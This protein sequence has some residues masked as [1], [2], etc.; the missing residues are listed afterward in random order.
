MS[1]ISTTLDVKQPGRGTSGKG[2]VS[3]SKAKKVE[4]VQPIPRKAMRAVFDKVGGPMTIQ[5]Y[6][7]TLLKMRH[8]EVLVR[9]AYSGVCHT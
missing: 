7:P 3:T 4:P 5:E 9:L 1:P 2:D 8:D 6:D